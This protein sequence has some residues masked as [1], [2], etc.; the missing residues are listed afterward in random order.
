MENN[1]PTPNPNL[2][3]PHPPP[4]NISLSGQE[5]S[6]SQQFTQKKKFPKRI[7]MI[8]IIIL[9]F[10]SAGLFAFQNYQP[11][12]QKIQTPTPT[13][14]QPTPAPTVSIPASTSDQTTIW[15]TY[16]NSDYGFSF[17]HPDLEIT[18]CNE[19]P[20]GC[21]LGLSGNSQLFNEI[22]L[23]KYKLPSSHYP[24]GFGIL[25]TKDSI[26]ESFDDFVENEE[27]AL[28]KSL[29]EYH[30]VII[31][32]KTSEELRENLR[33][34]QITV[35]GTSGY[36]LEGYTIE[37]GPWRRYYFPI[38]NNKVLAITENDNNFS[39]ILAA[40]EFTN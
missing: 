18:L 30:S 12:Q 28:F 6:V 4:G 3:T 14:A 34:E 21:G 40:F 29:V 35:S 9:L 24:S 15:K 33:Y 17:K 31:G 5:T 10:G 39:Q 8:L 23:A 32:G 20:H 26:Q 11:R 38:K 13:Q 27:E 22:L 37:E 7:I 2:Q 1:Q 36:I 19:V 16:T 25:V